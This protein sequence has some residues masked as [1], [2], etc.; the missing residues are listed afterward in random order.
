MCCHF[1]ATKSFYEI[2]IWEI[3]YVKRLELRVSFSGQERKGNAVV[4]KA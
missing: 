3:T 2:A 4:F 1:N